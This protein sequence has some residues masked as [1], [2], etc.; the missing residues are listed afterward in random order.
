MVVVGIDIAKESFDVTLLD[1]G[2]KVH[3]GQFANTAAGFERLG[4]WLERRGV[5]AVH[6]CMEATNVYWEELAEHL[7][8]AGHTVSVVN[9]ARIKGY[10]MSQM[11]RSKTDQLDSLVIAQFCATQQP[12]VWNPPSASQRQL[13]ALV[14]HV[15]AVTKT[16]TQ[17]KNRL[18]SCR[19]AQVQA[20]LRRLIEHLEG[21]IAQVEAQIEG[22]IDQ[23]PELKE[24][25]GL[26]MSVKGIGRKTATTLLAEMYDLEA[27]ANARAA[28]ADAGLTPAHH[29]SGCSVRRRPRL[30]KIGKASIRGALYWPAITA[31]EHNPIVRALAERLRAKGKDKG[32]ILGAAMR[33][34][35]HLA[36]GVLK[37]RTPFDPAYAA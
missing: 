1:G 8:Q 10:A 36:Y 19:D 37:H 28:A 6:A 29:E 31:I 9:P 3:Q 30:S 32:V 33:K 23:D 26:L 4:R 13:R 21:E 17:Q 25:Q 14:R 24:R 18:A 11:R 35:L 16:L 22:L 15:Q 5:E 7:H 20:S 12:D 34:L 2:G 27:Y